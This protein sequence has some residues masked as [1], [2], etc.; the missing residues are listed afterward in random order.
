VAS[1]TEILQDDA[2]SLREK[3]Q[4]SGVQVHYLEWTH[5]PHAFPVM[6]R[7]L[8]EARAALDS[9]AQF[10]RQHLSL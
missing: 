4:Q 3:L 7:W 5:T 6:C 9:T 10:I 8:P 2:L 1:A